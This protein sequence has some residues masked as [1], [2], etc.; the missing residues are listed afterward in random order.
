MPGTC[1]LAVLCV[2]LVA[3]LEYNVHILA[4]NTYQ[5]HEQHRSRARSNITH[6]VYISAH[7]LTILRSYCT[8]I[9]L[10][11]SYCN[12]NNDG[13]LQQIHRCYRI[14]V[15]TSVFA[16]VRFYKFTSSKIVPKVIFAVKFEKKA[17]MYLIEGMF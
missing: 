15:V 14:M 7:N 4:N 6:H 3:K 13:Y 5:Q 9:P 11:I 16:K 17:K 12:D 2:H 8:G 10:K 1:D